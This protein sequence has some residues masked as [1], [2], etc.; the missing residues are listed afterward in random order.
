MPKSAADRE[1]D[2]LLKPVFKMFKRQAA[3]AIR[4]KTAEIENILRVD[5]DADPAT[6]PEGLPVPRLQLRWESAGDGMWERVCH[7]ELV[8]ALQ[9]HD[10]RNDAKTGF[11]VVQLGRTRQGG[12]DPDW[13]EGLERRTPFRDGAHAKWDAAQ[14]GG[15]PVYVIAP[16]GRHALAADGSPPP[17]A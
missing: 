10:C 17:P 16:D 11:A 12:G 1:A 3:A 13:S 9:E 4:E 2:E 6:R 8:F 7:Y 5:Y 15:L 14:F